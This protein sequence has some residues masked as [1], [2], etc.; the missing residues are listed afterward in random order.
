M[1]ASN[2]IAQDKTEQATEKK[3]S[4]DGWTKIFD[5]KVL[6]K[7]EIVD[8]YDFK[9]HGEISIADGNMI[10]GGGPLAT[11]VRFTGKFPK[12]NYELT[13]DAKRVDGSDFFCGLTFPV[14]DTGLT[15]I[16]GGW[17]G[18]GAGLSNIDGFR[19]IDNETFTALEFENGKWYAVKVAVTENKVW[20]ELDGKELV[21]FETKDRD[22]ELDWTMEPC[23]PLGIAT[24]GNT[25]GAIRNIRYRKLDGS[26]P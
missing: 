11:G 19:A 13:L 14:G 22:I 20:V 23:Q 8:K 5:G 12:K 17:G 18:W 2:L 1:L 6:G 25:T 4:T 24:Y 7:W 10:L 26:A 15:L 9:H 3:Q 16:L 21:E